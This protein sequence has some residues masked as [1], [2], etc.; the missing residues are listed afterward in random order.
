MAFLILP[1]LVKRFDGSK[2]ALAKAIGI[3]PSALSRLAYTQPSIEVCLRLAIAT[4]EDPNRILRAAGWDDVAELL[5]SLYG[6]A[7]ARKLKH[8]TRI[9]PRE[10]RLLD[11]LRGGDELAFDA[12]EVLINFATPAPGAAK[13]ATTSR[14][15]R[16]VKLP[17]VA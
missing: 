15:M 7:A 2:G 16:K 12:F 8:R 13:R 3:S 1:E 4:D 5:E 14:R 11:R 10:Q 6:V 17:K 9:T